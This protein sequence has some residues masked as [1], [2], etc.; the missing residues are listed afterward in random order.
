MTSEPGFTPA[1]AV[2]PTATLSTGALFDEI[3]ALR[4]L[5][6]ADPYPAYAEIFGPPIVVAGGAAAVVTRHAT[7]A[8]LLRHGDVSARRDA[9]PVFRG[10]TSSDFSIMDPPE[11]TRIRRVVNRVFTAR[12]IQ[13]LE[14]WLRRRVD[15]LL[16][17][18]DGRGFDV[19]EELAYP[20][21]LEVICQL[22]GVPDEHRAQVMEWSKPIAVGVDLLG[23]RRS[24][25]EQRAYRST[26]RDFRRLLEALTDARR[27][28][29]QDDL[30]SRLSAPDDSGDV[31]T[32]REVLNTASN[33][34]IAGHETTVSLIG[35]GVVALVE[36]PHLR[37][38]VARD[39]EAAQAF[40]EEVLRFES[41]IQ[42]QLRV[43]RTDMTL[44][45]VEIR[46]GC[47][48]LLML[49]AANRDPDQ[50]PRPARFDPSRP[51][52]R[53]HLAFGAGVHFCV[54]APLARMEGRLALSAIASRAVNPRL[55]A[56]GLTYAPRLM[57][58]T[59]DQ[60]LLD[61]D[62]MHPASPAAGA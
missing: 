4:D 55:R 2:A 33:L 13:L 62:T 26:V 38:G 53:T 52:N 5:D 61:T 12:S 24:R 37:E 56:G 7:C 6:P 50:F 42:A 11:H 8:Q 29:P 20:L 10:F 14:P 34:L 23:G 16:D 54:G 19:I 9:S 15:E 44:D 35:H 17:E 22:L 41:P 45:G 36:N 32:R 3:P 31:L 43:A 60:L 28:S 58:R 46:A 57:L 51:S 1:R 25:E 49:G 18:V 40:V 47:A 59:P 48:L 27:E 21:P 39:L 30:L